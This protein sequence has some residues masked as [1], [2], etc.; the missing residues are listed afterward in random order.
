MNIVVFSRFWFYSI[1]NIYNIVDS[2][3]HQ[4]T[5][6]YSYS[7]RLFFSLYIYVTWLDM[8]I[9]ANLN[10]VLVVHAADD[11]SLGY[12]PQ[13]LQL[14]QPPRYICMIIMCHLS[15]SHWLTTIYMNVFNCDGFHHHT[16]WPLYIWM[17]LIV[18]G[19]IITLID[20]YIYE[21]F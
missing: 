19:F 5:R 1:S 17:F 16:D 21:C 9:P 10:P 15:S 12:Y 11:A 14:P 2:S 13:I 7:Q 8:A 20:H 6:S 4:F 3:A 18:T